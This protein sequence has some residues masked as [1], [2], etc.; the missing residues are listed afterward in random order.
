[1]VFYIVIDVIDMGY[2]AIHLWLCHCILAKN[3]YSSESV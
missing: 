1:M 3:M 2:A